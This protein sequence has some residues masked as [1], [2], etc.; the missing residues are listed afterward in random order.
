MNFHTKCKYSINYLL[1]IF[2]ATPSSY[3]AE[4]ENDQEE[5]FADLRVVKQQAKQLEKRAELEF[6]RVKYSKRPRQTEPT[7]DDCLYVNVHKFRWYS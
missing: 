1:I 4:E 6:C 3:S 2:K 7:I 5:I